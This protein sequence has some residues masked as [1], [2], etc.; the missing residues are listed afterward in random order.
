MKTNTTL[1]LLIGFFSF[2]GGWAMRPGA[3]AQTA[4]G[5]PVS[6]SVPSKSSEVAANAMFQLTAL[7]R[8]L[9]VKVKRDANAMPGTMPNRF[10]EDEELILRLATQVL[11]LSERVEKLE[12]K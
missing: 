9:N 5:N 3:M 11:R 2:V 6:P 12:N 1:L 4:P 7:I 8:E 10:I